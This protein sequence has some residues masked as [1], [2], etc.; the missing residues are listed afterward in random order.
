MKIGIKRRRLSDLGSI[1]QK[2]R[3]TS[4]LL[5]I[6]VRIIDHLRNRLNFDLDKNF[7]TA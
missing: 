1:D 3:Y 2:G 7:I 6:C 5:Y 4:T